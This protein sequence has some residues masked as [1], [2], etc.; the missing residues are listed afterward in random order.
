MPAKK[1]PAKQR[2][3]PRVTLSKALIVGQKIKQLNG[4]NPWATTDV[5][6]AV[7][8]GAKSSNF[9]YL[10]AAS[11]DFGL[12]L[13]TRETETIELTEL[14]RELLYAPDPETELRKKIEAF[15]KIEL[16]RKVL[17]HYKGSNLPEM[18]YLGNTLQREFGLAPEFH[19][20][21]S[22]LFRANCQD[23]GITAGS[24]DPL[25]TTESGTAAPPT[26]VVGEPERP[27]GKKSLTLF[28]IMPFAEKEHQRPS[29]FFSE[30]LNTLIT[31]AGVT[32][33]FTVETANRQG[34][35][36]I[37]STIIN[38][39]LNADIVVADLTDHN[40]NVLFELGVRMAKDKPVALIKASGTG[41]IFDV[42]NMLRVQEYSSNLWRSTIERDLPAMIEHIRATWEGRDSGQSYMKILSRGLT[43]TA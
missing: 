38:D 9:Y 18:K 23:L 28:V 3:F 35:D 25:A 14:G 34:S 22:H 29:G 24:L 17:E 41:R 13:G 1:Q 36:V 4:G 5:A 16:F 27:K 30:V 40:P 39:L 42:D 20:E 15:T 2:P 11:R 21:F 12:T 37:Q 19:D 10:T 26:L 31:P 33:G 43:E 6:T 8:L 32:C 7:E